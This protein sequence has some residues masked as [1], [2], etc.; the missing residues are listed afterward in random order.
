M[1]ASNDSESS[2][3]AVARKMITIL[4]TLI[5]S[6]YFCIYLGSVQLI[7]ALHSHPHRWGFIWLMSL[8]VAMAWPTYVMIMT[9]GKLR[10]DP[11]L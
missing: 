11:Y 10:T 3:N 6:G 2:F 5:V 7:R 8:Q 9:A 4:V 1:A